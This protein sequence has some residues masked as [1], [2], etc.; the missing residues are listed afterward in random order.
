M[1]RKSISKHLPYRHTMSSVL[2]TVSLVG[3]LASCAFPALCGNAGRGD[4]PVLTDLD[5][6]SPTHQVKPRGNTPAGSHIRKKPDV[7]FNDTQTS[8]RFAA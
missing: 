6:T 2:L 1:A 7:A 4:G 5:D 3:S 8:Y